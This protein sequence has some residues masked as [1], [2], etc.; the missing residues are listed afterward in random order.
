MGHGVTVYSVVENCRTVGSLRVGVSHPDMGDSGTGHG[1]GARQGLARKHGLE[2][3]IGRGP[4]PGRVI[5]TQ[6]L[7]R[8]HGHGHVHGL[9]A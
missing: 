8:N 9:P 3:F 6:G 7:Q 5:M 2:R 4:G 1:V